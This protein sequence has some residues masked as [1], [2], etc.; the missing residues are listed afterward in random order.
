[1]P[2]E[3][4]LCQHGLVG[5]CAD[6]PPARKA[7]GEVFGVRHAYATGR[8]CR[9]LR[10]DGSLDWV[11]SHLTKWGARRAAERYIRTGKVTGFRP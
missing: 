9:R 2:P 8:I 11:T 5:F 4:Q 6:C 1:M 3:S 7:I 10:P